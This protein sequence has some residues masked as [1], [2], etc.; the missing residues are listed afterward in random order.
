MKNF[1]KSKNVLNSFNEII[2]ES[3]MS[4]TIKEEILSMTLEIE[5]KINSLK[6]IKLESEVLYI[7]SNLPFIGYN[8]RTGKPTYEYKSSFEDLKSY[9]DAKGYEVN[10]VPFETTVV[11][12]TN[13]NVQVAT[14]LTNEY[15]NDILKDIEIKQEERKAKLE[16][17]LDNSR[18]Q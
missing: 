4:E 13:R 17:R 12:K 10:R 16:E 2:E 18:T 7:D 8:E 3:G 6:T 5:N 14:G 15:L 11:S 1:Y 9:C